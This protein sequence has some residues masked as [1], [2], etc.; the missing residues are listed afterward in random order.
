[1]REDRLLASSPLASRDDVHLVDERGRGIAI[2]AAALRRAIDARGRARRGGWAS[3][4]HGGGSRG[5]DI[6]LCLCLAQALLRDERGRVL[7]AKSVRR[8]EAAEDAV[9]SW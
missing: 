4:G 7:R 1:M 2:S 8:L 3:A 5:R 6:A 9:S